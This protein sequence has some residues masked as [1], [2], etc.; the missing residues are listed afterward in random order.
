MAK[1]VMMRVTTARAVPKMACAVDR[2]T[3]TA[4]TL[5]GSQER[6]ETL[7][8][9]SASA[10]AAAASAFGQRARSGSFRLRPARTQRLPPPTVA[11]MSTS[12]PPAWSAVG[13]PQAP[14]GVVPV[15]Q[16]GGTLE[17]DTDLLKER[18]LQYL[19]DWLVGL[20]LALPGLVLV[21]VALVQRAPGWVLVSLLFWQLLS[22]AAVLWIEVGRA[23]R[24]DGQTYGMS[25][26]DIQVV[27]RDTLV[28]PTRKQLLIRWLLLILVDSG[29]VAVLLIAVTQQ[30]QRL[31]DMAAK[32]LVVRVDDPVVAAAR[33]AL[34]QTTAS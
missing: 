7:L 6:P 21:V 13:P 16:P 19:I 32:T 23:H 22:M 4:R 25:A 17:P 30:H 14:P 12:P 1:A 20:G 5:A 26:L 3:I 8:P 31:G 29:L 11:G 28:P 10:H 9:P 27:D 15:Y 34:A 18:I 24:H 33:A 2:A